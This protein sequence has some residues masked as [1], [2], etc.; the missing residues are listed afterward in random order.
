MK[1]TFIA[2]VLIVI[3]SLHGIGQ[4]NPIDVAELTLKIGVGKTEELFY[5]FAKDDQIVFSFEEVK[6]KPLKEI[7]VI[8]LP[9]NSK[10]MDYKTSSIPDKKI[11]VAKKSVYKFSFRN[12]AL[13]GRI[14]KIKIQRIPKSPQAISFNTDWKWK[15]LYDTTYTPYTED[16]LVGYD[17]LKYKE[18]IKELMKTEK[19]DDMIMDKT[20]RVHSYWN[21]NPSRTYLRVDLPGNKIEQYKEEKTIAWAYWIGVGEEASQAYEENVNSVG[22]LASGLASTFGT[23][24][25]GVAVGAVTELLTPKNGEDVQ[26]AFIS[27]F[28]NVQ[29]F[30]AQQTYYQ[31]DQGKG[32]AAYGKSSNGL[33]GTFYIGLYNDNQTT[34]IDVNVKIVVIKEVKY[35]EEV[36]YD[37]EK[38]EPKYVSLN[39]ERMEVQTRKIRTTVE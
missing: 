37:R 39:K 27:S 35:Y 21:E 12:T 4:E 18:T 24:L 23:P 9:N 33:Q 8:E 34:G 29:A 26:Y 25:A 3:F 10:F 15:T 19:V 11:K 16:S 5:S 1:K 36:E 7:E 13:K 2:L 6:G 28:E 38:I 20:Q 30:L 17:T 32:V 22:K 31:F 14:C